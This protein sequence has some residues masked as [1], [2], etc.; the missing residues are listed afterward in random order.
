[1]EERNNA[2]H[3]RLF[4]F[5]VV[6]D[7]REDLS[8]AMTKLYGLIRGPQKERH[9]VTILLKGENYFLESDVRLATAYD[10]QDAYNRTNVMYLCGMSKDRLPVVHFRSKG[11][12]DA[13]NAC[14]RVE[15]HSISLQN[16]GFKTQFVEFLF[17]APQKVPGFSHDIV[18][19]QW[20]VKCRNEDSDGLLHCRLAWA[21][22][23]EDTHFRVADLQGEGS[24]AL[25]VSANTGGSTD[26][27][28]FNRVSVFHSA[29][30]GAAIELD[31]SDTW[32]NETHFDIYGGGTGIN[33]V[34]S[35]NVYLDVIR[36]MQRV[37]ARGQEGADGL[38][39]VFMRLPGSSIT[40]IGSL[41]FEG[42]W[43]EGIEMPPVD[44]GVYLNNQLC[45]LKANE[46]TVYYNAEEPDTPY[47]VTRVL[48]Q[49]CGVSA[50]FTTTKNCSFV[51]PEAD[52]YTNAT[53]GSGF[54]LPLCPPAPVTELVTSS[55]APTLTRS[56]LVSDEWASEYVAATS[57]DHSQPSFSHCPTVV[58]QFSCT[59]KPGLL[60]CTETVTPSVSSV[61]PSPT[62]S[63]GPASEDCPNPPV[64]QWSVPVTAVVC[65]VGSA[66]LTF[67]IM[68]CVSHH[69]PVAPDL[70]ESG[71]TIF[72]L[73]WFRSST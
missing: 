46:K 3:C 52:D 29:G 13:Q 56:M 1:M 68:K 11:E 62:V 61:Q 66:I 32:L 40:Y 53:E 39:P 14:Q 10:S 17:D 59:E 23:F 37:S 60:T 15:P 58:V 54:S 65:S 20:D 69:N 9:R 36:A 7:D 5:A 63:V 18:I 25:R 24:S 55:I 67:I 45:G 8:S 38:K 31:S 42:V 4:A 50:G 34:A 64:Y 35:P 70:S 30:K 19:P 26:Y 33:R 22:I 43:E 12:E 73:K 16:L 41:C 28:E 47:N 6:L 49:H 44:P 27:P 51:I 21:V 2:T 48:H 72:E 57:T 71:S